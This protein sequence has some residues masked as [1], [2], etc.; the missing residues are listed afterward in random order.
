MGGLL[1]GVLNA[2]IVGVIMLLVGAV[3]MMAGKWF[4]FPI[5][6]NVQR[7]YM[8]LVFLVVIFHILAALFGLPYWRVV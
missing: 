1:L 4:G 8:L 6:W 5:D 2:F 7:L 3:I